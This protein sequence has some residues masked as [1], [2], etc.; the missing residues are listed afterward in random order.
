MHS[1]NI[2][3]VYFIPLGMPHLQN[4]FQVVLG[5]SEMILK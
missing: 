4:S 5:N 2:Y 3:S 1:F